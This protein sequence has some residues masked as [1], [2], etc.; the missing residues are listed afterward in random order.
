MQ[1]IADAFARR[2]TAELLRA[3]AIMRCCATPLLARPGTAALRAAVAAAE[4][5][6]VGAAVAAPI[7]GLT[8]RLVF[9]HFCAGEEL[10]DCARVGAPR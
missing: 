9:Q 7:L 4:H 3:G 5:G 10:S 1:N 2:P 6:G 8:R